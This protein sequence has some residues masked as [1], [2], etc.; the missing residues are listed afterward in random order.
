MDLFEFC[1]SEMEAT[2][3]V[4]FIEGAEEETM[5]TFFGRGAGGRLST[6]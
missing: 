2:E 3:R 1:C 6:R 5:V 4:R